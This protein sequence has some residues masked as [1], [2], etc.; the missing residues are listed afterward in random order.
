MT[1]K[2]RASTMRVPWLSMSICGLCIIA[3]ISIVAIDA[4]LF[5]RGRGLMQGEL[6]ERLRD[7]A[8]TAAMQFDGKDFLSVDTLKGAKSP[9]VIAASKKLETL[10]SSIPN[11]RYAYIMRKT[12]DPNTFAFVADADMVAPFTELDR[13]H[14]GI[15][16][17]DEQPSIPGEPYDVS[18]SPGLR[19]EAFLH[20][21]TDTLT[22]DQWGAEISGYAPIRRS[23][24]GEATAVL[25]VDMGVQDYFALSN[26]VFSTSLF[27][28]FL[29]G[30][31]SVGVSVLL[32]FVERRMVMVRRIERERSGLLLLTSHQLGQ[33]LTIFQTSLESLQDEVDSPKL[34]DA[35][36]EHITDA[37][38][39][40]YRMRGILSLVKEAASIED[41][42]LQ[43]HSEQADLGVVI[44]EVLHEC[45]VRLRQRELHVKF[46]TSESLIFRFDRSL[47]RSALLKIV[48]NAILYSSKGAD[49]EICTT[50]DGN[51][52]RIEVQD[53]GNG[54]PVVDQGRIFEKFTRGS[55]ANMF[56][57]DGVGLGLFIARGVVTLAG[58][59]IWIESQEG[60]GTTVFISLPI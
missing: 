3:L 6:Q 4:N 49:I 24:T 57:P 35:V 19:N 5:R 48:D 45:D 41:K 37:Q 7:V 47:I 12:K 54:I 51:T 17:T 18:T 20:P 15:L 23:D 29:L 46:Q 44:R 9:V 59:S 60:K 22:T 55:N 53:H 10:R 13:N 43:Y 40:I 21:A 39:G 52:V 42:V 25:G 33:P 16:D 27:L 58:G 1:T 50:R 34:R 56:D 28:L 30:V 26:R 38:G 11:I 36:I 31:G 8:A 2:F 14:N 32:L